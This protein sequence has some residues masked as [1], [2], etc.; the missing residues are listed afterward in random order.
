MGK[1]TVAISKGTLQ[2]KRPGYYEY[3]VYYTD[4][5][6]KKKRKSFSGR[7]TEELLMRADE[8]LRDIEDMRNGVEKL[9]TIPQ[10]LRRRYELDYKNGYVQEPSYYRNIYSLR[11]I[12][13]NAIGKK[14]IAKITLLE[15]L[16]SGT[17]NEPSNVRLIGAA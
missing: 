2:E 15:I 13:E 6:N 16:L 8:F 17:L 12:E 11:R 3:R 7:D 4:V 9:A 5:D 1:Q 14:P 10:I